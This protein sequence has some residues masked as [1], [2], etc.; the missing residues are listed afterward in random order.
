[1]NRVMIK[2]LLM[3]VVTIGCLAVCSL[4]L[5]RK[6]EQETMIAEMVSDAV[7]EKGTQKE[8]S[9]SDL[10]IT[11]TPYAISGDY[12]GI[13]KEQQKQLRGREEELQL[14]QL[15]NNLLNLVEKKGNE[16]E[17]SYIIYEKYF[18]MKQGEM[19][20]IENSDDLSV[21]GIWGYLNSHFGGVTFGTAE[22]MLLQYGNDSMSEPWEYALPRSL[23]IIKPSQKRGSMEVL[24]GMNFAQIQEA[25]YE[26]QTQ[27]GFMYSEDGTVYYIQY[28]EAHYAYTFVSDYEDGR[29]SWLVIEKKMAK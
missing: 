1:M 15:Q 5:Q 23:I 22:D 9:L 26:T 16:D 21:C 18:R 11:E 28:E 25:L 29:D 27:E 19:L 2:S 10:E 8:T 4:L 24:A 7:Q 20:R 6:A 14:L 3:A 17:D 12:E 13:L